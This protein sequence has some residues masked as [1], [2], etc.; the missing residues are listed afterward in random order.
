MDCNDNVDDALQD[1][2]KNGAKTGEN[3]HNSEDAKPIGAED[4]VPAKTPKP[5]SN[6]VVR[7]RPYL[8]DYL[9]IDGF[10][11]G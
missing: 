7:P 8:N 11:T 9:F 2:K 10:F 1:E 4:R 3:E 6:R 5:L